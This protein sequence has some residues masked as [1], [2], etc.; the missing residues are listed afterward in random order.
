VTL[1]PQPPASGETEPTVRDLLFE[2]KKA[3]RV[4]GLREE[5][6]RAEDRQVMRQEQFDTKI[7]AMDAERERLIMGMSA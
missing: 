4:R 2:I 3:E 7:A 1:R 6:R 5:L